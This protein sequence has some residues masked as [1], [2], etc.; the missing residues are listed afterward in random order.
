MRK[1]TENHKPPQFSTDLSPFNLC[2]TWGAI[3]SMSLVLTR[4][5][6]SDWCASLRMQTKSKREKRNNELKNSERV[7]I[8]KDSK[9]M[10]SEEEENESCAHVLHSLIEINLLALAE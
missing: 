7:G 9:S 3:L 10:R 4:V 8:L 1:M 2:A 6:S 5:A